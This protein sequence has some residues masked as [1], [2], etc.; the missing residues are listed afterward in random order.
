M[1]IVA[2]S[3]TS[4]ATDRSQRVAIGTY[5]PRCAH[6]R[7]VFTTNSRSFGERLS[8]QGFVIEIPPLDLHEACELLRK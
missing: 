8:M 7:I 5:I 6:G 3:S 1:R 2:S 4:Q